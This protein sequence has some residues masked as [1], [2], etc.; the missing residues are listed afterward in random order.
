MISII[1]DLIE[2]VNNN[3]NRSNLKFIF[4]I[5]DLTKEYQIANKL[6]TI[7]NETLRYKT[8]MHINCTRKATHGYLNKVVMY[9]NKHKLNNM[10][11]LSHG[12]CQ[13]LGCIGA[14]IYNY[15]NKKP[16]FCK[17]HKLENMID[18]KHVLCLYPNCDKQPT[19]NYINLKAEFCKLHAIPDMINVILNKN[20]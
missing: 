15:Y 2:C 14:R 6:L 11:I 16:A 20:I 18:L 17:K 8:C 9:C 4:D 1:N 3:E 5:L 7:F 10:I 12:H 13:Y 19:H